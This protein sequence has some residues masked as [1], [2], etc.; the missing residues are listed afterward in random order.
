MSTTRNEENVMAPVNYNLN[1]IIAA[2]QT[3]WGGTGQGTTRTWNDTSVEYSLPSTVPTRADGEQTGFRTMTST[4][5]SYA[6][7]AFEL[8]DDLIAIDLNEV[9]NTDAQITIGMSS[10][11]TNGGTY[12]SPFLVAQPPGSSTFEREIERERIWLNTGWTDFQSGNFRYGE[13][14]LETMLHEIGHSLGL[15][16]PGPYDASDSPAPT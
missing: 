14:G 11:T 8:W 13:R 6:R 3:Q 7:L 4:E 5:Q 12:A 15:S 9:N 1:Q 10:S 2:L 16:H